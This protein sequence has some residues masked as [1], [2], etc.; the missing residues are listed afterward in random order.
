M[1]TVKMA[2]LTPTG[3]VTRMGGMLP[4]TDPTPLSRVLTLAA[5]ALALLPGAVTQRLRL[6][7]AMNQTICPVLRLIW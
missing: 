2:A 1:V 3:V 7:A 4:S 6:G 5:I